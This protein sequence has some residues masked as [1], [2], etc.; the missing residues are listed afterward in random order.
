M[1]LLSINRGRRPEATPFW[2]QDA[3]DVLGVVD[4]ADAHDGVELV[5]QPVFIP[6]D[7]ELNIN[8]VSITIGEGGDIT[9]RSTGEINV[10]AQKIYLAGSSADLTL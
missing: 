9:I 8:G 5:D 7:G 6:L 4:A 3:A 1:C 10:K 2:L